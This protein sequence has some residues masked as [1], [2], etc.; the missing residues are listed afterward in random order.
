MTYRELL[1]KEHPEA[2]NKK[3]EGGCDGCPFLYGYEAGNADTPCRQYM[4]HNNTVCTTCWDRETP[5]GEP[6]V[7]NGAETLREKETLHKAIA[8]WGYQSQVMMSFEEMAELQKELCKNL[9]GK[10]NLDEIADEVADV[11]IMLT[12]IKMIY[13]IEEKVQ[14]HREYKIDRLA[15]RLE[16]V[17]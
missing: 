1:Q 5:G 10:D 13:G 3:Y 9:R 14:E 15:Q 6:P 16:G 4:K 11:E 12:Q 8:K 17:K 7:Q 2:V